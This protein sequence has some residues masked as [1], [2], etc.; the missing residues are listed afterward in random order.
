MLPDLSMTNSPVRMKVSGYRFLHE[1][2]LA[3][4]RLIFGCHFAMR[5]MMAA[6]TRKSMRNGGPAT[7]RSRNGEMVR[8]VTCSKDDYSCEVDMSN[9]NSRPCPVPSEDI[10]NQPNRK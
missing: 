4:L 5:P 6:P 9:N 8:L 10:N 7:R 3:A 1:A 2:D